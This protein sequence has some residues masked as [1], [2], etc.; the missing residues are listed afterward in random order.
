VPDLTRE[1]V[2]A[3]AKRLGHNRFA[4]W[5]HCSVH[6]LPVLPVTPNTSESYCPKCWSL[7]TPDGEIAFAERQ[8]KMKK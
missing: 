6:N 5:M 4:G 3:Y 8:F 7:F 2:E 1:F